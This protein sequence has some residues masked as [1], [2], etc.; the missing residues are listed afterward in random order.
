MWCKPASH[1]NK[2]LRT[3]WPCILIEPRTASMHHVKV[4]SAREMPKGKTINDFQIIGSKP[5]PK[6]DGLLHLGD[7]QHFVYQGT[8]I[9]V[10]APEIQHRGKTPFPFENQKKSGKGTQLGSPQHPPPVS[11]LS[12]GG[13]RVL[14]ALFKIQEIQDSKCLLSCF[15]RKKWHFS[16]Q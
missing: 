6:T 16:V 8:K 10:E 9:A 13:L 7:H 12:S 14:P 4:Q 15:Q 5:I 1:V 11:H 2:Y 3:L